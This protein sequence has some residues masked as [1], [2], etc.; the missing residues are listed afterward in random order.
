MQICGIMWDTALRVL[1]V[2]FL[3]DHRC[4]ANVQAT[5]PDSEVAAPLE[6]P[7]APLLATVQ[8]LIMKLQWY[9]RSV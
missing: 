8:A 5:T 4:G 6:T 9:R 1:P 3:W 7:P 2:G